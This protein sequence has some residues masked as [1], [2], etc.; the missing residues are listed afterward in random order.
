MTE[1][2]NDES[3]P[4]KP[5]RMHSDYAVLFNFASAGYLTIDRNGIIE[6]INL[7]ATIMLNAPRSKL[8]GRSI[9]DCIHD[10]DRNGFYYQKL[11]CQEKAD[12]DTFEVKMR[13]MDSGLFDAQLRIQLL[14]TA[15][16]Q[17]P[18]YLMSMMDISEHVQ[19]SSAF[20]LQQRCLEISA[21]SD[22]MPSLLNAYVATLKN[23]LG[24]DAVGI[25]LRD[26]AG[27]I[28][29]MAY[30]GF[31]PAFY[32]SENP[33]SLNTDQCMCIAVI[34]GDPPRD[35]RHFTPKGAFYINGTSRF[36]AS[37]SPTDR[38]K[39]RNACNAHGYESVAL[40][41]IIVNSVTLGLIHAADRKED[42]FPLRLV[43]IL[44]GVGSRLGMTLQRFNLQAELRQTV[45][46]LNHLSSHL[47]TAQEDE[48]RRIAM[49]LHDGCGQDLNALKLRLKSL[50]NRLPTGAE[51]L[52]RECD[53]LMAYVDKIINDIRNIAHGLKP[54]ALEALGLRVAVKQIIR[55]FSANTGIPVETDLAL[56]ERIAPSK[57]QVCLFR[58]LQEALTNITKHA[59]ASRV[60]VTAGQNDGNLCICIQDNGVG[61]DPRDQHFAKGAHGNMGLSAM[62]LRC[63]MIGGRLSIDSETG[64][65]TRLTVSLP[66]SPTEPSP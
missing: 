66:D 37:V 42:A 60:A 52:G 26:P 11:L 57:A 1:T 59:R 65:G 4:F 54:A 24:C 7:A 9:T 22:D 34:K 48:Q 3:P 10:D 35:R 30:D 14:S 56:L 19:L 49:E 63:R 51:V 17:A 40:V 29:Y 45:D 5:N 41:P 2:K 47:L 32:E 61:F 46:T 23:Y 28:P 43:E 15:Y 44:E 6:D 25:R 8:I 55:E 53:Q 31:S 16:G 12:T 27:N 21:S 20:Y 39:M 38:G 18:R 36:L 62:A 13:R 33:L 50:Q 64:R 58:I